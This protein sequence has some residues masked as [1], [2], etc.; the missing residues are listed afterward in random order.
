MKFNKYSKSPE[1]HWIRLYQVAM[2]VKRFEQ[3][4]LFAKKIP[5]KLLLLRDWGDIHKSLP[6]MME[7]KAKTFFKLW[8]CNKFEWNYSVHWILK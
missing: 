1:V 5:F 3:F 6:R 4:Q 7:N 8:G 2:L